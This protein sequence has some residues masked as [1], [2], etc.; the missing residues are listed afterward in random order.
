MDPI[1][2]LKQYE[3]AIRQSEGGTLKVRW[4][5][6]QFLNTLKVDGLRCS[7]ASLP[8]GLMAKLTKEHGFQKSELYA[9]MDF[10]ATYPTEADLSDAIGKYGSWYRIVREGLTKKP[11]EKAEGTPLTELDKAKAL[12][13]KLDAKMLDELVAYIERRR[14]PKKFIEL[15]PLASEEAA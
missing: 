14:Q 9:R 10:A 6:G 15:T 12:V 3:A 11:R 4:E 7:G 5:C 1:E 13:K 2:Q 8:R